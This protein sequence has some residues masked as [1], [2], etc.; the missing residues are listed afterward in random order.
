MKPAQCSITLVFYLTYREVCLDRM[1]ASARRYTH[2][3]PQRLAVFRIP[4]ILHCFNWDKNKFSQIEGKIVPFFIHSLVRNPPIIYTRVRPILLRARTVSLERCTWT[5]W[6]KL[7][8]AT[9]SRMGIYRGTFTNKMGPHHTS[10]RRSGSTYMN[11]C[12]FDGLIVQRTQTTHFVPGHPG[13]QT[14]QC[15]ISSCGVSSRTMFTSHHFQR[16]YLNCESAWILQWGTSHRTCLRRIWREWE[17]RLDICRVTRRA[18][19]ECI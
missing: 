3:I 2:S 17:Y 9:N 15:V 7:V 8:N 5:C 18:H 13:H 19:I 10:I 11:T 16:H 1:R 4:H 14:W 12:Q 6:K